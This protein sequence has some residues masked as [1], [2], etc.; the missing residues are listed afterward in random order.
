LRKNSPKSDR[1]LV[2]WGWRRH[3]YTY[4]LQIFFFE[5]NSPVKSKSVK[6]CSPT[7]LQH[8]IE[9]KKNTAACWR[10]EMPES[11]DTKVKNHIS[12]KTCWDFL[13]FTCTA[14]GFHVKQCN[15]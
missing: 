2:S 12:E 1:K 5:I 14:S 8:E 11:Q 13:L 6:G 10:R 9:K 3:I 15:S 7:W 4:W